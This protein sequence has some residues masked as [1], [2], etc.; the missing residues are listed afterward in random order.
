MGLRPDPQGTLVGKSA[1]VSTPCRIEVPR[2]LWPWREEHPCGW[3][4]QLADTML[5]PA[6]PGTSASLPGPGLQRVDA[7][8]LCADVDLAVNHH[9]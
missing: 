2:L 3:A 6:F 5:A 9:G 7:A 8:V 4:F 1:A